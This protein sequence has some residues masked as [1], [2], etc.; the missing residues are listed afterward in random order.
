MIRSH[1]A[2]FCLIQARL[3]IKDG[4]W[5]GTAMLLL[6]TTRSS[7]PEQELVLALRLQ[8]LPLAQQLALRPASALLAL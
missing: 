8:V 1:T 5:S 2:V 4:C 6:A 7:L 3:P